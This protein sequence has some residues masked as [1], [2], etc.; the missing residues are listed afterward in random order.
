[1]A[2]PP[3]KGLLLRVVNVFAWEDIPV[4]RAY[5]D[6]FE[7]GV[8]IPIVIMS[9]Y[10]DHARIRLTEDSPQWKRLKKQLELTKWFAFHGLEAFAEEEGWNLGQIMLMQAASEF[11]HQF[12]VSKNMHAYTSNRIV[13]A[14]LK[15]RDVTRMLFDYFDARF[16]PDFKGDRE[17]VVAERRKVVRV[18][19]HGI[20]SSNQR[21]IMTYI[22]RFFRYTLRTNYYL[23]HKLGL[24]FRLDP[25]ILAPMPKAERPFG[26][27]CFHGPYSF[28]FHVRYRDTARGGVR[29]VRTWKI[30]RAH[31]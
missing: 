9:F 30:G 1:M 20:N 26:I 25:I 8:K 5:S 29:V 13:Y 6:E 17:L 4:D 24:S 16:D 12:L 14:V 19:I 11:A 15:H 7:R 21:D 27:Y 23:K 18:A 28:A 3:R 10:L 31:V 22:Y 2:N